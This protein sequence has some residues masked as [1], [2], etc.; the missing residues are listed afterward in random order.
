MFY[1]GQNEDYSLG[2]SFSNST[3]KLLPKDRG[4]GQYICDF[5]EGEIH[6]I[7]HI[8]FSEDFS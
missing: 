6:A 1:L 2:D 7:K 4:K 8:F 3:E 5:G